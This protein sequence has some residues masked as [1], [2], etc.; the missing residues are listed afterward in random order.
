MSDTAP[1]APTADTLAEQ[2]IADDNNVIVD[3]VNARE[4]HS[5]LSDEALDARL[6]E[7]YEPEHQDVTPTDDTPPELDLM[8]NDT[9]DTPTDFGEPLKPYERD[10]LRYS[11]SDLMLDGSPQQQQ[12]ALAVTQMSESGE[13]FNYDDGFSAE[14]IER[15]KEL[16]VSEHQI[17]GEFAAQRADVT[18][19]ADEAVGGMDTL[20]DIMAY[21][22]SHFSESEMGI[23]TKECNEDLTKSLQTLKA[24]VDNERGRE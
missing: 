15:A 19:I 3:A 12:D 21:A 14:I 10:N 20:R 22:H 24:Y 17:R 5:H 16:G 8:P 7:L 9:V 1:M 18:R 2:P 13:H 6:A 23:L 4:R 11:L